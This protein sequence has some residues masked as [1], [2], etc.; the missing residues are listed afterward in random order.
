MD[1]TEL[2]RLIIWEGL[3]YN[4]YHQT[5]IVLQWFIKFLYRCECAFE[6]W[7]EKKTVLGEHIRQC[8]ERVQMNLRSAGLVIDQVVD[9]NAKTSAPNDGNT[10]RK[11]FLQKNQVLIVDCVEDKYK[12]VIKEQQKLPG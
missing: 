7:I 2:K 3:Y 1:V 12:E 11:F 8:K 9:A 5:T 10:A 4:L 6:C